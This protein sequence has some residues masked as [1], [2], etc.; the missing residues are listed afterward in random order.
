MKRFFAV[1]ITIVAQ[2]LFFSSFAQN[3]RGLR[4]TSEE[5]PIIVYIDQQEISMPTMSCFVA[6]LKRS[7]YHIKIYRSSRFGGKERCVYNQKVYYNGRGVVNIVVGSDYGDSFPWPPQDSEDNWDNG[8]GWN[9]YGKEMSSDQ[10]ETFYKKYKKLS[11]ESER[12]ELLSYVLSYSMLY[13]AQALCLV[14]D[15]SFN[16][17]KKKLI[18]K[19]YPNIIDKHNFYQVIEELDFSSDKEEMYKKLSKLNQDAKW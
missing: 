7:Y 15:C 11:F 14:K 18:E 3:L 17:E 13:S 5:Y 4:I 1:A 12:E 10:F 2:I 16:S 8:N 9:N 19:V 6:N